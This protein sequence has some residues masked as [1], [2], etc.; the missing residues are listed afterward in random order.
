[1][2]RYCRTISVA[3]SDMFAHILDMLDSSLVTSQDYLPILRSD[4][5]LAMSVGSRKL[6]ELFLGASGTHWEVRGSIVG[7]LLEN[8]CWCFGI[9]KHL[10]TVSTVDN[11][12]DCKTLLK[13][14]GGEFVVALLSFGHNSHP[15]VLLRRY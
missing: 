4:S 7:G 13:G 2:L 11:N 9:C 12:I 6:F 8:L 1:M 10:I 14:G 5:Q 3:I 15:E